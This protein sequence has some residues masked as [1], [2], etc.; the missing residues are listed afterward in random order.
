MVGLDLG[1]KSTKEVLI[2]FCD[3]TE[4][5]NLGSMPKLSVHQVNKIHHQLPC[6]SIQHH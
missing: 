1:P 6:F 2:E 3:A 4:L 5:D